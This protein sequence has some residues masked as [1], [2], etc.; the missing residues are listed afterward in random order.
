M[1]PGSGENHSTYQGGEEGLTK[2]LTGLA[3]YMVGS[4]DLSI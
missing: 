1:T 3:D 4:L 2:E